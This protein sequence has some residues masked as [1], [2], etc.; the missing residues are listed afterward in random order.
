V[1]EGRRAID[2]RTRQIVE[3]SGILWALAHDQ[4]KAEIGVH[5]VQEL[6]S[7]PSTNHSDLF[8]LVAIWLVSIVFLV[9]WFLGFA[10]FMSCGSTVNRPCEDSAAL[11][12]RLWFV[13]ALGSFAFSGILVYQ[14]RNLLWSILPLTVGIVG[15][16]ITPSVWELLR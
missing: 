16:V 8:D 13:L 2:A 3:E 10:L 15:A 1:L 5:G 14:R 7:E 11:A 6:P 9:P 12:W 4:A